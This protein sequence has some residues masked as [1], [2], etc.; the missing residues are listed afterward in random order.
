MLQRVISGGQT[1]VDQ[2][3]LKAAARCGIKTGG[4]APKG[5]VTLEG[6]AKKLLSGYGLKEN[7]EAGYAE[8]TERNVVEADATLRIARD[9]S[10]QGEKLTLRC[11]RKWDRRYKDVDVTEAEKEPLYLPTSREICDW[12][13]SE[14]IVTLNVAGNSEQTSKGIGEIAFDILF[15]AFLY[16]ERS[17]SKPKVKRL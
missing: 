4:W 16:Y 17:T 13:I 15:G 12:L 5:W 14:K 6:N 11:I 2:A 8:R 10:T 1:G 3:A 9:F 7:F